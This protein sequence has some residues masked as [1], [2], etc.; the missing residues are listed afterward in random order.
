[1]NTTNFLARYGDANHIDQVLRG[2]SFEPTHR[3][4]VGHNPFLKRRHIDHLMRNLDHGNN[5]SLM[6][7]ALETDKARAS[8][9][10]TLL[11]HSN[12]EIAR[13]P[14][15]SG[16][17]H[18]APDVFEKALN[19]PHEEVRAKAVGHPRFPQELVS[20]AL[21]DPSERVSLIAQE[22]DAEH[23]TDPD[24]L[25]H[26]LNHEVMAINLPAI[27]NPHTRTEDLHAAH[28]KESNK[29]LKRELSY[30]IDARQP[31]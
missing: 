21:L 7:S 23:T 15:I 1:M 5:K 28:E 31:K 29:F 12:P 8:D 25:K 9:I 11:N 26:Y 18:L 14:F 16:S 24:K 27:V 6:S 22:K 3:V 4:M 20:K 2:D 10:D 19:S 17:I 30:A 13:I